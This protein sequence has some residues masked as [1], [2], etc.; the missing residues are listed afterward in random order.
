MSQHVPRKHQSTSKREKRL[1]KRAKK[2]AKERALEKRAAQAMDID[3]DEKTV[4][5]VLNADTR[6]KPTL[7]SKFSSDNNSSDNVTPDKVPTPL[8]GK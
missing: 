6:S 1:W 5:A 3:S 4:L 8:S 2:I 7:L